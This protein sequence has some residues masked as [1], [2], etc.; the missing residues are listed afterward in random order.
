MIAEGWAPELDAPIQVADQRFGVTELRPDLFIS[1]MGQLLVRVA[2]VSDDVAFGSGSLDDRTVFRKFQIASEHEEDGVKAAPGKFVEYG[3]GMDG[4]RP[5][6]KSEKDAVG[7]SGGFRASRAREQLPSIARGS[8]RWKPAAQCQSKVE[9][10]FS[11][12]KTGLLRLAVPVGRHFRLEVRPCSSWVTA[13]S[14]FCR[15]LRKSR[16]HCR[17]VTPIS[18]AACR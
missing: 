10:S 12:V 2:M 8:R 9:M 3:N 16:R 17:F 6:I 4:M 11:A 7:G 1:E 13:R 5:I 18:P 14:R 15:R